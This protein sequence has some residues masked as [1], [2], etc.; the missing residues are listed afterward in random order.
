MREYQSLTMLAR[1]WLAVAGRVAAV[2]RA[3]RAGI[4]RDIGD[5]PVIAGAQQFEHH[6]LGLAGIHERDGAD[7]LE[8]SHLLHLDREVRNIP[9]LAPDERIAVK[10]GRLAAFSRGRAVFN[11][12]RGKP[13][14]K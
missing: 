2:E 6:L 3:Q 13:K 7:R 11:D 1:R 10:H 9:V 4:P 14:V 12:E 5:A 8:R